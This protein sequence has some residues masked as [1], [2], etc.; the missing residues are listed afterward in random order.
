M[1]LNLLPII[2]AAF[3]G[4]IAGWASWLSLRIG[5]PWGFGGEFLQTTL[6]VGLFGAILIGGEQAITRW[7]GAKTWGLAPDETVELPAGNLERLSAFREQAR[8]IVEPAAPATSSMAAAV[9][10]SRAKLLREILMLD[11]QLVAARQLAANPP[12]IRRIL[13]ESQLRRETER[14]AAASRPASRSRP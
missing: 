10:H 4:L 1:T 7:E 12:E 13:T 8:L 14:K 9:A 2:D 6:T 3:I 11:V 5:I